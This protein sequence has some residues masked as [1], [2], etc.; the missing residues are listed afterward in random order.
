LQVTADNWGQIFLH[1]S[2]A[3][4][5]QDQA[6]LEGNITD[7]AVV[8]SYF[9]RILN[10]KEKVTYQN[11]VFYDGFPPLCKHFWTKVSW[12]DWATTML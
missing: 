10:I 12:T 7:A 5:F 6:L 9:M 3:S 4:F 11:F 2:F 8:V 1:E